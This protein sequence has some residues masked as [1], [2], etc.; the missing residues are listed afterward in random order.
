MQTQAGKGKHVITGNYRAG[1]SQSQS[2]RT[3]D[4][5]TADLPPQMGF[6]LSVATPAKVGVVHAV[7]FRFKTPPVAI[8]YSSVK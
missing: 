4:E 3:G 7:E 1:R 8:K 2:S 5:K 6:S